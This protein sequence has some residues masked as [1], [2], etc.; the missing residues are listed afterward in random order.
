[1]EK[2]TK[3]VVIRDKERKIKILYEILYLENSEY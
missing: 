3:T 2:I 1:M